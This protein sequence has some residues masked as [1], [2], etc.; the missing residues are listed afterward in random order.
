MTHPAVVIGV[1]VTI[2]VLGWGDL[3][4]ANVLSGIAVAGLVIAVSPIGR[5]P[6]R[7]GHTLRPVAAVRLLAFFVVELLRS[8][9]A[10]ARD[11]LGSRSRIRTGIV[12]YPLR[13]RS[14]G[15]ATFL[16]NVLTLTP[17]TMPLEL[18]GD[19]DGP[20][21]MYLH[22]TRG[23]E[24]EAIL[25]TVARYEELAVRAFGSPAEVAAVSSESGP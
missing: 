25:R 18:V 11:L 5:L 20:R 15:L 13:T 19:G 2:W 9:V 1:L 14:D 23:H 22:V 16:V 24:R 17:G 7:Q 12:G 6:E 10:M 3:S 21:V 4:V 8:N